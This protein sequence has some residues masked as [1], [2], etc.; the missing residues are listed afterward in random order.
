VSDTVSVEL[1]VAFDERE[2]NKALS[3][4]CGGSSH[5][6]D[7]TK[8]VKIRKEGKL[9]HAVVVGPTAAVY[10]AAVM[11]YILAE[12]LEEAGF[13]AK[14]ARRERGGGKGK[15]GGGGG[16]SG[17]GGGGNSSCPRAGAE[18]LLSRGGQDGHDLIE[19]QHLEDAI[20]ND[21]AL[22]GLFIRVTAPW[23]GRSVRDKG[24]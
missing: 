23:A 18:D 8:R 22:S 12:L 2:W 17:G 11:E 19:E 24:N 10:L 5:T 14:A 4:D 21:V 9:V 16:G 7:C 15:G 6:T 13:V 20:H 3:A 1:D